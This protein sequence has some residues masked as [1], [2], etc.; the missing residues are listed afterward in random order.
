MT[1]RAACIV[2]A[3]AACACHKREDTSTT[4]PPPPAVSDTNVVASPAPSE[5]AAASAA[6]VASDDPHIARQRAIREAAE[7]GLI[8]LLSADSAGVIG[9]GGSATGG[10]GYGNGGGT[11]FGTGHHS[12]TPKIRQGSMTVSGRLPPEVV[13]RIVRQN[14]GRFRLCYENGLRN[15]PKLTGTVVT[16]FV[17]DAQGA[18]SSAARDGSTTLTDAGVVSCITQKF[19]NFSF[20]QPEGGGIVT[21]VYPLIL[22]PGD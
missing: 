16:K 17:I 10:L 11:R 5:T 9:D 15:D 1:R 8:G 20:P 13:Q 3:A 4:A 6:P 22:E 2:L 7:V 19:S 18:V 12:P 21:V 14:F